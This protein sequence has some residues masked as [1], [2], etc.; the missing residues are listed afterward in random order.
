MNDVV[1]RRP[2]L[3]PATLLITESQEEFDAFVST[4]LEQIDPENIIEETYV[5]DLIANSWQI[6]RVRRC[7]ATLINI[8]FRNALVQLLVTELGA[9]SDELVGVSIAE[10]WFTCKK[11]REEVADLLKKYNLDVTAIEAESIKLIGAELEML[12]RQLA[13]LEARRNKSIRNMREHRDSLA[14]RARAVS[15]E[16]IDTVEVPKLGQQQKAAE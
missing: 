3:A 4:T 15:Q 2:W 7:I 12:D 1:K 14:K 13:L 6:L 9:Y 11:T 8:G 16:M 10:K 5:D